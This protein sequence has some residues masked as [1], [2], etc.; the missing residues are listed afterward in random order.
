MVLLPLCPRLE[1][2]QPVMS[3]RTIQQWALD[4]ADHVQTAC[5]LSGIVYAFENCV[6]DL[7]A[8]GHGPCWVNRHPVCVAWASK[9][10]SLAGCWRDGPAPCLLDLETLVPRFA[11]RMRCICKEVSSTE[12]R[13]THSDAQQFGREIVFVTQARDGLNLFLALD[14]CELL[15]TGESIE[16][17]WEEV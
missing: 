14:A 4:A 1:R 11:Q 17:Y 7:T 8:E 6:A 16:T 9:L 10:E 3:K 13:N 12:E 15:A 5:N 2:T